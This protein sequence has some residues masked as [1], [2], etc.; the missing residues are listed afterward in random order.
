[1]LRRISEYREVLHSYSSRVLPLVEWRTNSKLN[2]E[3]LNETGDFYR[4]FDATAHAEFL[5]GCVEETVTRDLP[6]EVEYLEK[7]DE[8]SRRVQEEIADMPGR[9]IDLLSRFLR[10]N[11]GTLSKRARTREFERLTAVE[12]K[13]V[14]ALYA[15][16]FSPDFLEAAGHHRTSE[17]S[18]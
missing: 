4:F 2:I 17:A 13:R 11:R 10:Q 14:E 3:V 12:V 6:G 8:F 7:Y 18:R 9:T 5:Y 15:S 16:C 1:M